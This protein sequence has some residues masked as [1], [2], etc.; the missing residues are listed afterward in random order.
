MKREQLLIRVLPGKRKE[1]QAAAKKVGLSQQKYVIK[2]L[3]EA[4]IYELPKVS[5]LTVELKRIGTNLNQLLRLAHQHNLP[6]S[7]DIEVLQ[8]EMENIWQSLKQ[9]IAELQSPKQ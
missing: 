6:Q 7:R 8:K 2:L 4:R 5:E 3:E 1:L 9:L